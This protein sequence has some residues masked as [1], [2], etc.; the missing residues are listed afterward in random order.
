METPRL[1]IP[2]SLPGASRALHRIANLDRRAREG[3]VLAQRILDIA[4][5]DPRVDDPAKLI[6]LAR[7]I[8]RTAEQHARQARF[9][10][11][12]LAAISAAIATSP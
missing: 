9:L 2:A 6:R 10:A 8:E 1:A 11:N 5:S 12:Q 7:I 3:R 4:A